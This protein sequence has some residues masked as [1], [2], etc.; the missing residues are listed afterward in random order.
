MCFL[1]LFLVIIKKQWT[2]CNHNSIFSF[3]PAASWA[4]KGESEGEG[5]KQKA[6]IH[7]FTTNKKRI[8]AQMIGSHPVSDSQGAPASEKR[9]S[10]PDAHRLFLWMSHGTASE[11]GIRKQIQKKKMISETSLFFWSSSGSKLKRQA[12][13]ISICYYNSCIQVIPLH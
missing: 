2:L 3:Y 4:I 11:D 12:F 10:I 5:W 13:M 8:V 1:I 7:K 9:I 6:G